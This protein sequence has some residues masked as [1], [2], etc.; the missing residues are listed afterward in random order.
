MADVTEEERSI[1]ERK[2]RAFE[3]AAERYDATRSGYPE[4]LVSH[5]VDKTQ[6]GRGSQILEIG[7]G[8]GQ[9]T[10]SLVGRGANIVAIDPAPSM[11]ALAQRR[12]PSGD[13]DF[14]VTTFEDFTSPPSTF[15][16]IVSATVFHWVDPSVA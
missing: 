10:R 11:I 4:E 15:D 12:I 9:L 5:I 6:I 14:H 3:Q 8:T 1:R 16:L 2:R 13:V 7:C